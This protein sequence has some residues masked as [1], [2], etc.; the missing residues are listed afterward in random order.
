MI[1]N[2]GATV[3]EVGGSF[4]LTVQYA[5]TRAEKANGI[6]VQDTGFSGYENIPR[7]GFPVIRLVTVYLRL[8]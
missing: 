3:T 1:E 8:R 2:E 4:D 6:L 7:V 5:A